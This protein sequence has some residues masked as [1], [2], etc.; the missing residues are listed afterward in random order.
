M[1]LSCV[2]ML[3]EVG[4]DEQTPLG[5]GLCGSAFRAVGYHVHALESPPRETL[6][7]SVVGADP[8]LLLT[9]KK[10]DPRAVDMFTFEVVDGNGKFRCRYV[11]INENSV[12]PVIEADA[13][14]WTM[15]PVL[16]NITADMILSVKNPKIVFTG[17]DDP[18]V[19]KRNAD[20]KAG[21]TFHIWEAE[22][23]QWRA[24]HD[25]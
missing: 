15:R 4:F 1:A 20:I 2:I 19:N 23:E 5:C 11:R 18:I 17:D 10:S 13:T 14:E 25:K 3:A 7:W 9:V 6:G 22:A 24:Q 21:R 12:A 8:S 16:G